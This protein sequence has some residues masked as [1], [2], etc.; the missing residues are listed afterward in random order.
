[1]KG[2]ERMRVIAIANQKGGVGKTTSTLNISAGLVLQGRRVLAVDVDPPGNLSQAFGVSTDDAN[3]TYELLREECSAAEAIQQTA[4]GVDIIPADIALAG[5]E[6]ELLGKPGYE[7][8][9]AEALEK[10]S[11]EYDYILLD[12][13][14]S[15]G[16]LTINGLTAAK[17]VVIVMQP[18]FFSMAGTAQ[19]VDTI[20]AIQKRINKQLRVSGVILNMYDKRKILHRDGR[21]IVEK[22]FPGLVFKTQ[23]RLNTALAESTGHGQDIF[24]YNKNSNGADDYAALIREI[25]KQEV[26]Q[27]NE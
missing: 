14:P 7:F 18:E 24:S 17:E 20:H 1:M 19:L 27:D 15:L 10:V 11:G 6:R 3:T 22:N 25:L 4:A 21:S 13:P 2:V 12:C 9:L 26:I 5:S 16:A 23:I 8:L